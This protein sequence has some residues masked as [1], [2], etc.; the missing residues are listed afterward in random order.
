MKRLRNTREKVKNG[1]ES[2]KGE[3]VSRRQI[4]ESEQ[5]V[6]NSM[7]DKGCDKHTGEAELYWGK[8]T[9]EK[10]IV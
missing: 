1:G 9:A 10:G 7:E 5:E 4:K 2:D 3:G 6:G 8:K